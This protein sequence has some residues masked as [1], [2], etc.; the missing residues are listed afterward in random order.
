MARTC[1]GGLTLLLALTL[2]VRGVAVSSSNQM[3]RPAVVQAVVRFLA[4][5]SETPD[6]RERRDVAGLA[7]ASAPAK[8]VALPADADGHEDAALLREHLNL[9]PP[10]RA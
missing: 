8:L 1:L 9:P 10:T 5:A 3:P 7:R 4:A 6:V 2:S